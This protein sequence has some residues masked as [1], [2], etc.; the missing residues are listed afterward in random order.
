MIQALGCL[1]GLRFEKFDDR[2][3]SHVGYHDPNKE[4]TKKKDKKH[5]S[6]L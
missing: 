5:K 1:F 2:K 6:Q 3:I 4:R